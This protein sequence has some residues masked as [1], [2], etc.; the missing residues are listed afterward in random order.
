MQFCLLVKLITRYIINLNT[1]MQ[2]K[3]NTKEKAGSGYKREI[4]YLIDKNCIRL[5]LSY[6]NVCRRHT[7][8]PARIHEDNYEESIT[9]HG[10]RHDSNGDMYEAFITKEY[11]FD[12]RDLKM[13]GIDNF[14][15]SA[16]INSED[17]CNQI[18]PLD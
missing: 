5:N 10:L 6:E 11:L 4:D 3:N 12:L 9:I 2:I 8:D 14:R 13:E 7:V 18:F 1:A 15:L 16:R 17:D